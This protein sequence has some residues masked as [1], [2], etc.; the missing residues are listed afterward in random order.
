[1]RVKNVELKDVYKFTYVYGFYPTFGYSS[2]L[3]NLEFTYQLNKCI[4]YNYF[5]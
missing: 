5:L 4:F 1:M 2:F 3:I